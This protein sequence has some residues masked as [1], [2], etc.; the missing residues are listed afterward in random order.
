M[1][2]ASALHSGPFLGPEYAAPASSA[3]GDALSAGASPG[4][5]GAERESDT[6]KTDAPVAGE[7][8]HP[9]SL[10]PRWRASGRG[11]GGWQGGRPRDGQGVKACRQHH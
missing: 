1:L 2:L 8:Q 6:L 10:A 9:G 4:E 3:A 5:G 7:T 11:R